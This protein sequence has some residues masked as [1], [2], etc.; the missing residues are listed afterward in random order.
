MYSKF[1]RLFIAS[2][3]IML[4]VACARPS[5]EDAA[6]REFHEQLAKGRV[7][8]IYAN[9]SP[10]LRDQLSEGQFRRSLAE[11][12]T[13]GTLQQ[14]DREQVTRTPTN[15]GPDLVIAFYNSRYT[16]ASCLESF[17]WREERG[18]LKLAGYSCARNMQVRCGTGSTCETSPVPTPG[19]A[20]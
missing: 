14:S 17:S 20:G 12:R 3:I 16:A 2:A 10:F 1:V 9:A 18:E 4:S 15:G 5:L 7:D 8:L 6:V 13:L 11:T 19:F